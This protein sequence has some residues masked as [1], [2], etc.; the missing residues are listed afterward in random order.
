MQ[1][2]S[3]LEAVSQ[4]LQLRTRTRPGTGTQFANSLSILD[5][6]SWT[7]DIRA[8]LET[9]PP[10][11]PWKRNQ[12]DRRR[13]HTFANRSHLFFEN[14]SSSNSTRNE[15]RNTGVSRNELNRGT[16][17]PILHEYIFRSKFLQ[18]LSYL[19]KINILTESDDNYYTKYIGCLKI[20]ARF[21]LNVKESF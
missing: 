16:V 17:I 5:L 10:P 6:S 13:S 7:H 4:K 14:F 11:P 20:N 3:F 15:N 9:C 2:I 8:F 18:F 1:T 21:E 19:L 12:I